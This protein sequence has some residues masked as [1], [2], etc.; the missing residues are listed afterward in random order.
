MERVSNFLVVEFKVVGRGCGVVS[1]LY[2]Y[3]LVIF[4]SRILVRVWRILL[5]DGRICGRRVW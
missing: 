2:I 5:G 3:F 1:F 4:R